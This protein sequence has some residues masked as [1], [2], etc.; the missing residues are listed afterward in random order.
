MT[1]ACALTCMKPLISR[2]EDL[3]PTTPWSATKWAWTA[4]E[5]LVDHQTKARLCSAVLLPFKDG[6]P[7]WAS[8]VAEIR[9]QLA[10]AEHYG[11]ELVPVLN[12]DTGYIFD[13]DDRLYAEVLRQ[14]RQAFPTLKFIAG[15]TARGAQDD[16]SFKPERYRGLLDL[17]QAHDHCEVMIMT[18]KGLNT[19]D[20]ER[21]RDGYY[22]IAEWLIRPGIV[23]ALEPA[24]VPWATPYEPWLL[25][26]LA[27]HPKF[28]GGKVST[29][30][31][32][33]FL[34][35]AAMCKDLKL[36][37]APHSGDD[38]GI[39]T[40]IKTG[41]PLL[42][43]AASSAAPQICAAKDLWLEDGAPGKKF[44]T[45]TGRFD[46]R[47]YKLFEAFQSLEDQVFRLD[48]KGSA[49]AYKHSTAH[50]LH[51]LGVIASPEAHPACK[52]VRGPDEAARMT[53]AMVRTRRISARLDIPR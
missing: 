27:L 28:V 49:A 10:A 30:D 15:I 37:F 31:E 46:T 39:A 1:L 51:Q 21:R 41:L 42:I 11:V 23:H 22:Q 48:A 44:P 16:T 43:G 45:G 36:D 7:D 52:D 24:F 2:P 6:Q 26:Q 25:H 13:L 34:Y 20:P 4:E 50:L 18:S 47:V 12:A 9:W 38:Y 53:E 3:T 14:F 17:V 40:A 29:L 33:H 5:E 32:P 8:F 19:L 35:W